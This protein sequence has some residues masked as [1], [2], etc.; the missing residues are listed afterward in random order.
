MKE[1]HEPIHAWREV[2][3]GVRR[4]MGDLRRFVGRSVEARN[5]YHVSAE[6]GLST[7]SLRVL[8]FANGAILD[9]DADLM[10]L[11]LSGASGSSRFGRSRPAPWIAPP[12]SVAPELI[13]G[14]PELYTRFNL[15]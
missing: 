1:T 4:K 14:F 8:S 12:P 6:A 7:A 15:H 10:L 11:E 9:R 3:P 13:F 5:D 2:Q